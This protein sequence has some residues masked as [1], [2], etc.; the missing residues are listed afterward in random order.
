MNKE[1]RIEITELL[2]IIISRVP[3]SFIKDGTEVA[4]KKTITDFIIGPEDY[5]IHFQ[6]YG[7]FLCIYFGTYSRH[8]HI[9][10]SNK[11]I[12]GL[13]NN[14]NYELSDE[15]VKSSLAA[16]YKHGGDIYKEIIKTLKIVIDRFNA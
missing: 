9:Y 8:P 13:L 5:I 1:E 10:I 2:K 16:S 15:D 4:I 6:S 7:T 3:L 14:D 11:A 12:L